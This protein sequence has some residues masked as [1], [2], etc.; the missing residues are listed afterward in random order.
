MVVGCQKNIIYTLN[1]VASDKGALNV[2]HD[3]FR[4]YEALISK[5]DFSLLERCIFDPSE[6]ILEQDI[7]NKIFRLVEYA[8]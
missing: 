7:V 3:C 4:K 5:R 1:D 2:F 6:E 8:D